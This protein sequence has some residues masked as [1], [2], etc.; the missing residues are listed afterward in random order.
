[1]S[2]S[3]TCRMSG[4]KEAQV[5]LAMYALALAAAIWASVYFTNKLAQPCSTDSECAEYGNNGDPD[6]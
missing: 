4:D 2:G 6:V 3:I 5:K 1:M